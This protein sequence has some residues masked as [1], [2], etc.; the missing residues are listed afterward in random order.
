MN[1]GKLLL[2]LVSIA[3]SGC[4]CG[5]DLGSDPA[6]AGSDPVDAGTGPA[7]ART[8]ECGNGIDDD[9]NGRIDDGCSCGTGEVQSCSTGPYPGQRVGACRDGT[10]TC[11]VQEFG[12]WGEF[13]CRGETL[14]ST[15]L[16][17]GF[18][19][20]CDGAVDEDC[21]CTEGSSRM[22][23]D[24]F[25]RAPCNAGT[26][27]CRAGTWGSCD[28]AVAP[29]A[30]VCTDEIDNDCDG[31]VNEGCDC[32]STPE[33]CN[34]LIDN[35]CDGKVDEVTCAPLPDAGMSM[36]DAG[37]TCIPIAPSACTR[38]CATSA[39]AWDIAPVSGARRSGFGNSHAIW[40][41][42]EWL[43]IFEGGDTLE[44][45]FFLQASDAAGNVTRTVRLDIPESGSADTAAWAW[46]EVHDIAWTGSEL[47]MLYTGYG[48]AKKRG[49]ARVSAA[50]VVGRIVALNDTY[51]PSMAWNGCELAVIRTDGTGGVT[52]VRLSYFDASLTLTHEVVVEGP[53]TIVD[54]VDSFAPSTIEW[55]GSRWLLAGTIAVR[56]GASSQNV[57]I[58]AWTVDAG[59]A[60]LRHEIE[61]SSGQPWQVHLARG[62]ARTLL[63][64]SDYG[65]GNQST[66]CQ[67]FGATGLPEGSPT[68][69]SVQLA[70]SG[71]IGVAF[72][73][74][75]FIVMS[76]SQNLM[77]Q[78]LTFRS[79][80][81]RLSESGAVE[82]LPYP[83]V[84][85]PTGHFFGRI[86]GDSA[87]NLV[88]PDHTPAGDRSPIR[89]R[90]GCGP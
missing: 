18:D 85:N 5:M 62:V 20:D 19:N 48:T 11:E 77:Q 73:D 83:W 86:R 29:S 57:G 38:A 72:W 13:S 3:L 81:A 36:P 80:S 21:P 7:D 58:A 82:A 37:G 17:D 45:L 60:V 14:P 16:C 79:R 52:T 40:T 88:V 26:Q 22:C 64:W 78:S 12:D 41:G 90:L 63:C 71:N 69:V 43:S 24:E 27:T 51:S 42:T 65:G 84:G 4:V 28:G 66:R 53:V 33:Q 44:T 34:D 74:C 46:T 35:D 9:R 31:V 59:G 15:E 89:V 32:S 61:R 87:P 23:S 30:D 6:D 8:D 50:G 68:S 54:G 39:L 10:Q 25:A 1:H 75:S 49:L 55:T 2:A 70:N 47:L 67:F 56:S 76:T